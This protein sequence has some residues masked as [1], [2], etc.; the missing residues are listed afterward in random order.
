MT[1]RQEWLGL[2]IILAA[3][4]GAVGLG[5]AANNALGYDE[6]VYALLARHW[7]A[8]TP[9]DGVGVHR[10]ILLS[11]LGV[12]P[13]LLGGGEWAF[14]TIGAGFGTAAVLATWWIARSAGGAAAGLLAALAVAAASPFQVE[15][16]V[17]LTDVPSTFV[18]LV[19]A[20]LTWHYVKN[21]EAIGARFLLLAP[22]AATAFYLRYG[23]IVA[24]LALAVATLATRPRLL[25]ISWRIVLATVGLF[26]LLLVPHMLVATVA[27][28]AP[29]GIIFLA[30]GAAAETAGQL[31]LVQYLV[32][33]PWRLMG[34]LGA[35]LAAVGIVTLVWSL[36]S[37]RRSGSG[38]FAPGP[39]VF[40]GAGALLQM[41]ILGSVIHAEARYVFLPMILLIIAGAVGT[42]SAARNLRPGTAMAVFSVVS[43]VVLALGGGLTVREVRLRGLYGDW[44]RNL[45][46]YVRAQARGECSVLASQISIMSWYSGCSSYSLAPPSG[47][48]PLG[49]LIG[50]WR[51]VVVREGTLYQQEQAVFVRNYESNVAL[52]RAFFDGKGHPAAR[53]YRVDRSAP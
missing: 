2:S 20:G 34:P 50:E 21:S 13:A 43:L 24:I 8:G 38:S 10:P 32:L 51:Y 16:G 35:A 52:V 40:L 28:G 48:D 29:W 11:V 53:L 49:V 25:L 23:A 41:A 15:S 6:S 4:I 44:T 39:A 26:L 31:P 42:A 7:T 5:I 17:F 46:Q 1:S 30:Q 3:F 14:R 47:S 19:L 45:G 37:V 18:L 27:Q 33:F 36:G 9:V 22:V 12:L